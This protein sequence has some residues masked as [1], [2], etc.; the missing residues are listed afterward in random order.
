MLQGLATGTWTHDVHGMHVDY[1]IIVHNAFTAKVA[2]K[3]APGC[4]ECTAWAKRKSTPQSSGLVRIIGPC[5][6]RRVPQAI[7]RD[8]LLNN[9]HKAMRI[10]RGL[11]SRHWR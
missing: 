7:P 4:Y 3:H 2:F 6:Q 1:T 9:W 11:L 8:S 10:S 5:A